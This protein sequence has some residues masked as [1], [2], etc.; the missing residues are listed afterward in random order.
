M[1]GIPFLAC[2]LLS[3][4]L[5]YLGLHVLKR[6]V[7]FIDIAVA[8]IAALGALTAHLFLGVPHDSFLAIAV[9]VGATLVAALFFAVARRKAA[10][11]PI[12][13]IIGITY[14]ISAG[15]ALFM[16]AKGTGGHTH[17]QEMLG[18]ALLWVNASELL[19]TSAAF[20]AAGICFGLFRKPF[21][22]ISDGYEEAVAT[23]MPV[24]GWD[25]LFYALCG[26]VI[27]VSVR[28]AGVV[29]TFCFLIIP[30]TVSALFSGK[31]GIRLLIAW[32]AGVV[33]SAAGLLFSQWL[34]FSAGVC[35]ALFLGIVLATC[36]A[37]SM[38][39]KVA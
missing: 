17:V 12:E 8:Q 31:W 28:L 3:L 27:T 25:F 34:D 4:V 23:G 6:E 14:A 9:G 19:W 35:V 18:G 21:Q 2:V 5:G 1:L 32:V 15:G 37:G 33:S 22:R 29:V 10:Q 13:A 7:I 26:I 36:A 11:L 38:L 16:I 39:R 20:A 30:A 24:I